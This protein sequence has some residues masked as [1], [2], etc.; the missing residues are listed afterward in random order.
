MCSHLR[1]GSLPKQAEVTKTIIVVVGHNNIHFHI[2]ILQSITRLIKLPQWYNTYYPENILRRFCIGR[3]R[4]GIWGG[5]PVLSFV[6][7]KRER[8]CL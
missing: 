1:S 6:N 5:H 3:F 7:G 8:Q 4:V 2:F